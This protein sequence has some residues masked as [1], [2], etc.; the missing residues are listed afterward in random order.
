MI[1]KMI[2]AAG[3]GGGS[4][5]GPAQ[6][7]LK[8]STTTTS[9]TTSSTSTTQTTTIL[10][11]YISG[12]SCVTS[13]PSGS[14]SNGVCPSD[15]QS[16]ANCGNCNSCGGTCTTSTTSTTTSTTKTTTSVTTTSASFVAST[17][18]LMANGATE[19]IWNIKPGDVVLSYDPET[20]NFYPNVIVATVHYNVYQLY[21][22]NGKIIT[23]SS[24]LFFVSRN[25]QKSWVSAQNLKVGDML[26][27]PVTKQGIVVNSINIENLEAPA[28]VYDLIGAQGNNFIANGVLADQTTQ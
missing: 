10:T 23:D 19:Q 27:N 25:G 11:C 28:V 15:W 18:I 17:R 2:V 16:Y 5:S 12:S 1:L 22:I 7:E 8:T 24:E 9:T 4:C 6:G 21:D 13:C 14:A 3:S 20:N 26:L